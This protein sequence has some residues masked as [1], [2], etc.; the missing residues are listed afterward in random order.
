MF[1]ISLFAVGFYNYV[2]LCFLFPIVVLPCLLH[3][4]FIYVECFFLFFFFMDAQMH[5]NVMWDNEVN[6]DLFKMITRHKVHHHL[7][8]IF[9]QTVA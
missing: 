4:C 6:L 1:N 7:V 2:L 3:L 8:F 9:Y 5:P